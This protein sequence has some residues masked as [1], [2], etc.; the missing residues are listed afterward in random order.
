MCLQMQ[1]SAVQIYHSR[2]MLQWLMQ[3]AMNHSETWCGI[4][5]ILLRNPR[6][7]ECFPQLVGKMFMV[8]P[9]T[10]IV[11]QCHAS[12]ST[13]MARIRRGFIRNEK[14]LLDKKRNASKAKPSKCS[15]LASPTGYGTWLKQLCL[16][17][18]IK[19]FVSVQVKARQSFQPYTL[20]FTFIANLEFSFTL[21]R[22]QNKQG[23]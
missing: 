6:K 19:Q 22:R 21:Y 8:A 13:N 9:I 18:E 1:L 7:F 15:L 23:M 3:R 11:L 16:I 17:S 4:T 14:Q 20:H 5:L 10:M 12:C 2:Q